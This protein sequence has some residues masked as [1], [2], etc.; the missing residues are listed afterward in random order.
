[1]ASKRTDGI[2][3]LVATLLKQH[4]LEAA[5]D[6]ARWQAQTLKDER[7][8]SIWGYVLLRLKQQRNW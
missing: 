6:I 3:D 7:R 1:M 2:S 5:I 4:P 8:A